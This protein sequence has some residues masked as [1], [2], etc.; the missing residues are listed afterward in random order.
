MLTLPIHAQGH[1]AEILDIKF[2]PDGESLASASSDK[3]ILLWKTYGDCK[4]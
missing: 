4:K 2:S 3:T 1:G